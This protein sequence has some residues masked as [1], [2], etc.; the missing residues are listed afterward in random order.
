MVEK[1]AD[2]KIQNGREA[3]PLEIACQEGNFEIAKFFFEQLKADPHAI[4][5]TGRTYL[6]SAC[7]SNSI[8]MIDYLTNLGLDIN[9]RANDQTTPLYCAIG[10][11]KIDIVKHCIEK[12]NA[13]VNATCDGFVSLLWYACKNNELEIMKYLIEK[14]ANKSI[15]DSS[16]KSLLHCA[17]KHSN[18]KTID[19]V[20][21]LGYDISA[22]DNEKLTIVH[23]LCSQPNVSHIEHLNELHK[24][25]LNVQ[26]IH[27][28]TPLYFAAYYGFI[29]IVKW[30]IS[31]SANPNVRTKF[32]KTIFHGAALTGNVEVI[33]YLATHCKSIDIHAL[34]NDHWTGMFH[35][36]FSFTVWCC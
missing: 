20:I 3:T 31:H 22:M 30:L 9:A 11:S 19:F 12:Y 21:S 10:H 17:V 2:F 14:G 32:G 36:S 27:Q 18:T 29:E 15:T 25:D 7:K 35:C 4:E 34:D 8:E 33:E 6:H 23:I 24:L 16:G 28:Q 5:P 26:D 1:G 13:D